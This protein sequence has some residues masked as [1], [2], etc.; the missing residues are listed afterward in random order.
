MK[1]G[2]VTVCIALW[3]I[4]NCEKGVE[5]NMMTSIRLIRGTEYENLAVNLS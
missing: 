4:G 2:D 5:K 3:K 1:H